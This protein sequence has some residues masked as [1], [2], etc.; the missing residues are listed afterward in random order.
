LATTNQQKA[1]VGRSEGVEHFGM[2]VSDRSQLD[3]AIAAVEQAG[4]SLVDRGEH[5]PGVPYA[6]V[7]NLDGYIIEI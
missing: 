6:Y 4:G 7:K 2:Y 5:A 1:R 3:E